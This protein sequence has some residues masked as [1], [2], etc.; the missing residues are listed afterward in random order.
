VRCRGRGGAGKSVRRGSRC[1]CLSKKEFGGT[2]NGKTVEQKEVEPRKNAN[3]DVK[4]VIVLHY[5][6][7]RS[8]HARNSTRGLQTR[9]TKN[10]ERGQEA[11]V[12]SGG[13]ETGN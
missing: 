10:E 11:K 12:L 4:G 3:E 6:E 2:P 13:G 1:C 8:N 7:K 5:G 9:S